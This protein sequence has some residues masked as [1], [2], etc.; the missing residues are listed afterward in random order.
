MAVNGLRSMREQ[1]GLT[2]FVDCT[3][4]NI[5]RDVELLKRV[6]E[7]SEVHILSSTGFYYTEEPVLYNTS[8]DRLC[9]S[10]VADA[11]RTGAAL[12]KCAVE[13]PAVS[14]FQEKLLRASARA[15]KRTGLPIV[16]HTNAKNQNALPA[17]EILF[18][19]GVAAGSITVGHLSD[20]RDLEFLKKI[21]SLGCMIGLDRLYDDFSEE[22]IERKLLAIRALCEAGYED[23]ILLS[24]DALFFSGFRAE[25]RLNERPR[26]FYCFEYILPRLPKSLADQLMIKNPL[27][28]IRA[29]R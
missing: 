20:T 6:S 9:A 22:Y 29:G 15:H 17:L 16:L 1:Y 4:V 28:M 14:E 23:R 5:G 7:Q 12:I 19:E 18:S 8:A 11:E 2:G 25:P 24:H 26:F 21:A 27:R 13:Q 3:P 10:I